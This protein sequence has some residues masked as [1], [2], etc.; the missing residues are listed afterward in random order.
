MSAVRPRRRGSERKRSAEE[1]SRMRCTGRSC[2]SIKDLSTRFW[3]TSSATP[4]RAR[5]QSR[6][7]A[8]PPLSCWLTCP[9]Q[10]LMEANARATFLNDIVDSLEQ[11]GVTD[12]GEEQ[13]LT[14][15]AAGLTWSADV[16]KDL[17]SSFLLPEVS[18][19]D[20]RTQV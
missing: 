7:P 4:S 2:K 14:S 17:V 18:R 19:S 9:A 16:V 3:K 13:K 5:P 8:R 20:L 6:S 10:A 11:E 15:L 1:P 12:E